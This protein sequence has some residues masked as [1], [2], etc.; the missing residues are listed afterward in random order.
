M[1]VKP[2]SR[3]ANR[4]ILQVRAPDGSLRTVVGL[5]LGTPPPP[6]PTTETVVHR[7]MQGET[8]DAIARR[9]YGDEALWPRILDANPLVFPFDIQPGDLL[10]I[11]AP[12]PA[13]RVLRTRKF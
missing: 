8:I 6:S 2:D 3:F 11:P 4:P 9:Y 10:R 1:P 5:G 12:G 13:T 7:V